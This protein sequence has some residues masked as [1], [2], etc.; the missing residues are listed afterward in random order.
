MTKVTD[1]G[2]LDATFGEDG[3]RFLPY[4]NEDLGDVMYDVALDSEGRIIGA[5]NIYTG[6]GLSAMVVRVT[7]GGDVDNSFGDNG[8]AILKVKDSFDKAKTLAV[9]PDGKILVGGYSK[10]G[11]WVARVT[12]DGEIDGDFANNG[13][14]RFGTSGDAAHFKEV[15]SIVLNSDGRTA[16]LAGSNNNAAFA[17]MIISEQPMT[18]APTNENRKKL[19]TMK[20]PHVMLYDLRGRRIGPADVTGTKVLPNAGSVDSYGILL[21]APLQG[22]GSPAQIIVR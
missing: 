13:I 16:Y 14:F 15:Q 20:S 7:S 17:R 8:F 12:S 3:M 2:A 4:K 18:S 5:G 10:D 9:Q 21:A 11:G 19:G 6:N 1:Q 22:P